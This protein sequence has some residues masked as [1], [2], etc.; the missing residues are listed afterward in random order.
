M[1]LEITDKSL[2]DFVNLLV[3]VEAFKASLAEPNMKLQG[4]A[5]AKA[6]TEDNLE[7]TEGLISFMAEQFELGKI[8]EEWRQEAN[9]IWQAQCKL[10][11]KVLRA[12]PQQMRQIDA[13][14]ASR[15]EN[16]LQ[17]FDGVTVKFPNK[18]D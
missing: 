9:E 11:E 16:D 1:T 6:H 4:F 12:S 8:P 2:G 7:T 10:K 5:N 3:A 18:Y 14:F 13:L 17:K 15:K